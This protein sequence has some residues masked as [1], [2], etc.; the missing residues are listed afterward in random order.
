[1]RVVRT[2]SDL[3]ALTAVWY[4]PG[5][6]FKPGRF[7]AW[8]FGSVLAAGLFVFI[9]MVGISDNGAVNLM[10][11]LILAPVL[12]ALV[13][14]KLFAHIDHYQGVRAHG[15]RIMAEVDAV[16][17]RRKHLRRQTLDHRRISRS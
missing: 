10:I 5:G 6:G 7:T 2:D 17:A 14:P 15:Q 11:A 8:A 9:A 1:M 16:K 3:Y 12:S 13:T 4:G